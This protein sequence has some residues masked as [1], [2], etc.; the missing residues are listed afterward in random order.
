M[1]VVT[2]IICIVFKQLYERR[3]KF[4][5]KRDMCFWSQIDD[6]FMTEEESDV[7]IFYHP[8]EM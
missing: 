8:L 4:C 5:K 1:S 2:I 7:A 3:L 6:K